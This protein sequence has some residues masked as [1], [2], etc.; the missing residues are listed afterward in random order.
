MTRVYSVRELLDM[1]V[2]MV[3]VPCL[4]GFVATNVGQ[5]RRM[6]LRK[7]RKRMCEK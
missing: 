6:V 2:L 3:A 1:L 4:Y 5:V 7:S